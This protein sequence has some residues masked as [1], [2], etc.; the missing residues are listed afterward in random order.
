M[1]TIQR[2][3][4]IIDDPVTGLGVTGLT[5]TVKI[6]RN[7]DNKYL[8]FSTG[9]W[10]SSGGQPKQVMDELA[11]GIYYWDFDQS[12]YGENCERD[13][14]VYYESLGVIPGIASERLKFRWRKARIKL[15]S[16]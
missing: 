1:G 13:Y 7:V 2:L 10:V 5:P 3:Q 9:T 16:R 15:K 12:Q 6:Y 8:D 4:I 14:I 11:A